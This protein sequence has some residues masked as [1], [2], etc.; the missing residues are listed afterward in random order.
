MLS[1]VAERLYWMARYVERAENTA[2]LVEVYANLFL[3]LP[4]SVDLGWS[5]LITITGMEDAFNDR[6]QNA[7]ERNVVRYLLADPNHPGSVISSLAA[8][9]E[10]LRTTRDV[11][12]SEA[13]EAINELYLETREKA[14]Q[15]VNRGG[16]HA[17]LDS[18]ICGCQQIAGLL[19][20]TMSHNQGY[21]FVELGR[22]L[23]RA[24]MTTRIIDSGVATLLSDEEADS[25]LTIMLWINVLRS[26]S[27]Y[28]MYRQHVR[29]RVNGRDVARFLLADVEF[30]R[31]VSY[32]AEALERSLRRLPRHDRPLAALARLQRLL[33]QADERALGEPRAIH[34]YIDTIQQE[35]SDLHDALAAT[36]FLPPPELAGAA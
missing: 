15:A 16:R 35:I 25:L 5:T 4:R 11:V 33:E 14:Q 7:D 36:W 31:A 6:F 13:F 28:Q 17:W 34:E 2:R 22:H 18:V 32:C 20:G 9:R 24:D 10:N 3:D 29:H 30:P 19:M 27:G 12:P 8:A 23:E 26:S 1:R 21:R